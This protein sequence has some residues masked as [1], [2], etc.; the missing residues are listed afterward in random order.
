M[1][2]LRT[3]WITLA[4]AA[5]AS[6]QSSPIVLNTGFEEAGWDD[7]AWS[8]GPASSVLAPGG[9]E[10]QTILFTEHTNVF[11][12]D[13]H[14]AVDRTFGRTGTSSLLFNNELVDPGNASNQVFNK[15][16][17][18]FNYNR[19][20]ASGITWDG[21]ANFGG[22]IQLNSAQTAPDNGSSITLQALGFGSRTWQLNSLG[23]GWQYLSL[24]PFFVSAGNTTVSLEITQST[25][26]G[27]NTG[28]FH[29]DDFQFNLSQVPEPSS[30]ICLLIGGIVSLVTILRKR[31]KNSVRHCGT[32]ST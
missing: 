27:Q 4:W 31:P 16:R 3:L 12:T 2:T 29:L 6:A 15:N 20:S 13:M 11:V 14:T 21:I 24:D 9:W 30:G 22:W 8:Q 26:G 5:V 7:P 19:F 28:S 17:T 10:G 25:P 18:L 32:I 1:G 23:S